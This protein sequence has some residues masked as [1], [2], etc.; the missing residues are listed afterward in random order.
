[1]VDRLG[2]VG[3]VRH[4]LGV[5]IQRERR[6]P[7][8]FLIRDNGPTAPASYAGPFRVNLIGLSRHHVLTPSGAPA[9]LKVSDKFSAL[10]QVFGEPGLM[11]GGNGP[12]VIEETRDDQGHDL[13]S[14]AA[15]TP[16]VQSYLAARTMFV[17]WACSSIALC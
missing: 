10:I 1:M 16:S 15:M 12:L 13:R 7:L 6:A 8:I 11:L 5:P 9:E 14:R 3:G 4:N 2:E 17:G